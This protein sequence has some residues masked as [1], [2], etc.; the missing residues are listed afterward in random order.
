MG[1]WAWAQWDY[2]GEINKP[3]GYR[4]PV[5]YVPPRYLVM[6]GVGAILVLLLI[7]ASQSQ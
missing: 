7:V 1:L 6:G 2:Q 5:R 4:R 3:V